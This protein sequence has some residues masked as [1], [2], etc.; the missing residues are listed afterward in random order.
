MNFCE[1]L[2]SDITLNVAAIA[3]KTKALGPGT[4]AAIWVQ[5]CPLHCVG[6]LAPEWIPFIPAMNL[7][8]RQIV[9][10]LDF[11]SIC[12]LTFSGGEPMEQAHGLAEVAR[13]AHQVKDLDVICFTGYRIERLLANPPNDG[14][15]SLL[16]E[17]DV[18]VDGPYVKAL[19]E[20]L[21]L[22][23]SSNQRILHLTRR[24]KEYNLETRKRDIEITITDGEFSLIGIPTTNVMSIINEATYGVIERME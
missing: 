3:N 12:G 17:V 7:T 10:R 15:P 8:P 2:E 4:R 13:L 16:A 19:N 23:G 24:L 9:E 11:Q 1:N 21:G 14:V 18:L 22:R 5:G 20:G 6:C